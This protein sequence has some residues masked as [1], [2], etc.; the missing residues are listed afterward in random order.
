MNSIRVDSR[1]VAVYDVDDKKLVLLF[2]NAHLCAKYISNNKVIVINITLY[3]SNKGKCHKNRFDRTIC[4]RT[5][6]DSQIEILGDYDY[7]ILDERYYKEDTINVLSKF[8]PSSKREFTQ[9]QIIK[10]SKI[11]L[12]AVI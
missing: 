2:R 10:Y 7:K 4:F 8:D 12:R 3:I 11:D 5:A 9:K 1:P 6:N